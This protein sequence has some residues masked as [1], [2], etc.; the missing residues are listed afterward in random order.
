MQ[1]QL[2]VDMIFCAHRKLK[3]K[4]K[5]NKKRVTGEENLFVF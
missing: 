3:E 4:K 5:G 1:T 2:E